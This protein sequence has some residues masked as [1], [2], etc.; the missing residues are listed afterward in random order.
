MLSPHLTRPLCRICSCW[1]LASSTTTHFLLS[2]PTIRTLLTVLLLQTPDC[3]Y[4]SVLT[5]P[6]SPPPSLGSRPTGLLVI[7]QPCQVHVRD[8]ALALSAATDALLLH[9]C[10]DLPPSLPS[11]VSSMSPVLP[12]SSSCSFSL[13]HSS[14]SGLLFSL[15]HLLSVSTH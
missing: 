7:S 5:P 14:S 15:F 8:F 10:L 12:M 9:I 13:Q 11:G 1:S 2:A 3:C 6:C 4:F